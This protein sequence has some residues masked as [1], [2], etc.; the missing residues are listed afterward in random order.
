M[1]VFLVSVFLFRPPPPPPF[2]IVI[3]TAAKLGYLSSDLV[4]LQV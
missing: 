2:F 3:L 1:P 4:D